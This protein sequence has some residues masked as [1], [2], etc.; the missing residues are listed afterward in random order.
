MSAVK[1]ESPLIKF[2]NGVF[3]DSEGNIFSLLLPLNR[4][5]RLDMQATSMSILVMLILQKAG[6]LFKRL[7]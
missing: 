3:A 2:W 6:V 5:T 4:L 7:I 1:R